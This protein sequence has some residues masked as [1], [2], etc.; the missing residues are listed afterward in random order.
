M[1]GRSSFIATTAVLTRW[2]QRTTKNGSMEST[3][4]LPARGRAPGHAS[5][6]VRV[7]D[8]GDR[9]L[10]G[11]LRLIEEAGRPRPLAEVLASLCASIA[12]IARAPVASVY[13]LEGDVLVMRGNVGF[14]ASA[15]DSV[16]LKLGEGLTG[17]VAEC[18]R[19]VSVAI[20]RHDE[21]WKAVP[22]IGE[23]Q[24]P[25]YLGVPIIT[26]HGPAGVLVVQRREARAF[27]AAELALVAS[28]AAPVGFALERARA[29][30]DAEADGRAP[31]KSARNARLD[32]QGVAPGIA[33]GRAHVVP[34]LIGLVEGGVPRDARSPGHTVA[35]ALASLARELERA[36]QAVQDAEP[37]PETLVKLRA[38]TLVLD[39]LRF[40]DRMVAACAEEGVMR[41]LRTVAQEYARAPLRGAADTDGWLADRAREI[42]DLCLLVAARTV[43]QKVP[44]NGSVVIAERLSGILALAAVAR[45]AVAVA[46]T[47][48]EE[49]SAFGAALLR[50]VRL[51]VVVGAKGLF[52]WARPDDRVLVDGDSGIVRVNPPA[53]AVARFRVR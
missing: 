19:P 49:D 16:Q 33:L 50:A 2:K 22:G 38:L 34:A 47:G 45:R 15:V 12:E 46:T 44:E 13:V 40:R 29:R 25:S 17:F 41:G 53:S 7:H 1:G 5:V 3:S 39:D 4:S 42:E 35:L 28:L 27:P 37:D 52:A 20:G 10:D 30:A 32:G 14:P 31:A 8:R 18:L 11:I 24:Y 36:A 21:R 6:R 48:T 9:R 51:P 23:D 43:G 26:G